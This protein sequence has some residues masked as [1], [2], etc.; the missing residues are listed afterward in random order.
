MEGTHR[1]LVIGAHPD[2]ADTSCAGLLSK[3]IDAGWEAKLISV[4]D[5]G[6][7][8]YRTD[9]SREELAAVRRK[10]AAASGALIG[11]EYQVWDYPD[12]RLQVTL[13]AREQVIRCIRAFAPEVVLTNRPN[14]Y[15]AD[16]RNTSL[17][18]QDA[19]YLL[20]V[21]S[22]CSDV[23]AMEDAPAILFWSDGFQKPYPHQA[24]ILVPFGAE[25]EELRV[26]MASCHECQYFDWMY[27]PHSMHKREWTREAQIEDLRE[28]FFRSA[29][30]E[31][32]RLDTKI[33]ERF[34]TEAGKVTYVEAYEISEYGEAPSAA[35]L[36][37]AE[38][39]E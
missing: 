35:F 38:T 33:R 39:L 15:H 20:T 28:R 9:L 27:W 22:L 3:L 19:S 25:R 21:P 8:T 4:T 2:D 24:D 26:R 17:L 32:K 7:G 16:H 11:A 13:E 5:G 23:P 30:K 6:A 29:A 34:G 12:A 14:D 37:V 10:E 31:R 36:A 1:I 18:V